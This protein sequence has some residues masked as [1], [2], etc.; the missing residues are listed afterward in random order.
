LSTDFVPNKN[1]HFSKI[2]TFNHNDVKVDTIDE[3]GDV[4]LTDGK[5]YFYAR[6]G[7]DMEMISFEEKE[8][9]IMSSHRYAGVIFTR[10][11]GNDP[12]KIIEAIESF[13]DVKLISEYEEEF[14]EIVGK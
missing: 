12:D 2:K 3:D 7:S 14:D 11:G 4:I 13:F 8:P 5:N 6:H 10:Y 1:I 9:R